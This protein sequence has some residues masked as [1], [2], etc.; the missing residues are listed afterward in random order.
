MVGEYQ[1]GVFPRLPHGSTAGPAHGAHL[2]PEGLVCAVPEAEGEN[3]MSCS[4]AHS[5]TGSGA[6]LRGA[7]VDAAGGVRPNGA[8]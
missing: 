2:Y 7:P 6:R 4:Q 1:H 5:N 8:S 3:V